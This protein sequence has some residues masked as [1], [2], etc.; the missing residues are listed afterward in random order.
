MSKLLARL[1]PNPFGFVRA[2]TGLRDHTR[3]NRGA[4]AKPEPQ[5]TTADEPPVPHFFAI[6]RLSAT[7]ALAPYRH[8]Y[9]CVRCRWTF[10]VNGRGGVRVVD[11]RNQGLSPA[12]AVRRALTFAVGPCPMHPEDFIRPEGPVLPEERASASRRSADG[13]VKPPRPLVSISSR[14]H[15]AG[16]AAE[17]DERKRESSG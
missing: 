17:A 16:D 15:A 10:L 12:E 1:F 2:T 9:Y 7:G 4:A 5:F 6:E 8:R 13:T 14:A 3:E 11:D